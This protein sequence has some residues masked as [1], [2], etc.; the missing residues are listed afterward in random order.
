MS[1]PAPPSPPALSIGVFDSGVGGLS[2]LR[3]LRALMPQARFLYVADSGHAPYGERD[4]TYVVERARAITAHLLAQG[5]QLVVVACNTATAAAVQA[6]RERWPAVGFVGVEPGLKPAIA[7][8]RNRRIGVMATRGTL[9]SAKF[10]RLVE[11]HAAGVELV[12]QPCDGLAR[13]LE[14]GDADAPAVLALV[15][16]H[17]APLR[18]AGVDTVVL[19]CTHYPFATS[20]IGAAL[21]PGVA[22]IDTAQAVALQAQRLAAALPSPDRAEGAAQGGE[23]VLG[24][25]AGDGDGDGDGEGN[26]NGNGDRQ[27]P[28]WPGGPDNG[29]DSRP[30]GGAGGGART[31]HCA[32]YG[33]GQVL[34]WSSGE[35]AALQRVAQRWLGWNGDVRRLPEPAA[36]WCP[37]PE[38]NRYGP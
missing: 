35:P 32:G 30:D 24:T 20:A 19:G 9:Q 36:R 17:T 38:S 11:A 10:R 29:P 34:L 37:E 18:A 33:A 22:L 2:V 12:L 8:S 5:A 27:A 13:A 6:L 1:E 25:C 4:E 26:G 28:G 21:G 31:G 15:E 14:E 23:G 7:R 16:R 3:S